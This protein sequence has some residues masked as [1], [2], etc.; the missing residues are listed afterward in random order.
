[1]TPAAFIARARVREA[2]RLLE[3]TTLSMEVVAEHVGYGS[4]TVFRE[5][6][7][8][9]V[10]VSPSAYR[11]SFSSAIAPLDGEAMASGG[12]RV[13]GASPERWARHG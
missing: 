1:M 12:V 8:A 9:I 7:A 11:R 4:A 2:Q 13:V 10:G 3:T 6:F 5:R